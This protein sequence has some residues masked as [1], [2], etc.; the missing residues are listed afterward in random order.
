MNSACPCRI[1]GNGGHHPSHCPSLWD[2]LKEG[3][4]SGGGGG[5]GHSHEDDDEKASRLRQ[6][7]NTPSSLIQCPSFGRP[8]VTKTKSLN[9]S[10]MVQL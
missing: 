6:C 2:V 7:D 3:F 9:G 4:Y 1:C 10:L 5:G 8:I